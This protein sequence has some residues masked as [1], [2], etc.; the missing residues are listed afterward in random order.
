MGYHGAGWVGVC[1][2][3]EEG[4]LE[5][6]LVRLTKIDGKLPNLAAAFGSKGMEPR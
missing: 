6:M 3:G 5:S 4:G 2:Y 1:V